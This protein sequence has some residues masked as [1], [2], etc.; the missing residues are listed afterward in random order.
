MDVLYAYDTDTYASKKGVYAPPLT[1]WVDFIYLLY[2]QI[3][4]RLLF[5]RKKAFLKRDSIKAEKNKLLWQKAG[6]SAVSIKKQYDDA[7]EEYKGRKMSGP[8]GTTR[9]KSTP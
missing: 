8:G 2:H 9:Q 4:R 6:L 1:S 5:A 3:E 7:K